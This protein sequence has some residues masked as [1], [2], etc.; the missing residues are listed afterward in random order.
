[1]ARLGRNSGGWLG[2]NA[3]ARRDA[4]IFFAE[5]VGE[6]EPRRFDEALEADPPPEWLP[7]AQ[8]FPVTYTRPQQAMEARIL[9]VVLHTT[10]HGAGEETIARF[11]RDWQALQAQ[12]AHF[13]IDREG[14]IG[15]CRSTR[16]VAWHANA[17]SVRYF[18]IEHIAKHKQAL[19]DV[20]IERSARLVGDLSVY[21]GFPT[22]RLVRAETPGIG[23]HVDFRPTGCGQDVFWTGTT[24]QRTAAF[25][26]IVKRAG[27][28]ARWGI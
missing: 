20:Q 16:E 19:T 15:Q 11:Q 14:N 24:A 26:R 8:R 28:F 1:M 9:G 22:Q 23:I 18:G 12:S 4:D 3:R 27:D 2:G 10:N 25:D 13:V 5:L 7:V 21:F 17:P 6:G